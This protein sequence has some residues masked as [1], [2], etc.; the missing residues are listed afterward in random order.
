[1]P[2]VAGLALVLLHDGVDI[3]HPQVLL[4]EF[5]V[6]LEAIPLRELGPRRLEVHA[7]GEQEKGQAEHS[8][9]EDPLD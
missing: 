1:M 6:A 8:A 3:L 2:Q 4:G 9:S 7:T 5:L